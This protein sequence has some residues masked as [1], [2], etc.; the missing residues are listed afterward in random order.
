MYIVFLFSIFVHFVFWQYL[1]LF[2]LHAF[3]FYYVLFLMYA[4]LFIICTSDWYKYRF[5]FGRLSS[6]LIFFACG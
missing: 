5:V 1:A 4:I 6:V 2:T 3:V